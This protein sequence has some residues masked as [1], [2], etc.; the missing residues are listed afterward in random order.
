MGREHA[1]TTQGGQTCICIDEKKGDISVLLQHLRVQLQ[2]P[3]L[4]SPKPRR[5]TVESGTE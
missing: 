3:F 2:V 5:T 4:A 1:T